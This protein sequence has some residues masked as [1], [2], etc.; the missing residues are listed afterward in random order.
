MPLSSIRDGT[1]HFSVFHMY[2]FALRVVPPPLRVKLAAGA[3]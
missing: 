1:I 2:T 3:L